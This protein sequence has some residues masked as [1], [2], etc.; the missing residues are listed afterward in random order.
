MQ[1]TPYVFPIIGGRKVDHLM[2]N[3]DALNITLKPE[4]VK[5]LES[6]IPFDI[7]FPGAMIVSLPWPHLC[8]VLLY[9]LIGGLVGKWNGI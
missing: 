1:K 5:Y 7:G 9:P 8:V 2:A 3:I 4:H 6:I